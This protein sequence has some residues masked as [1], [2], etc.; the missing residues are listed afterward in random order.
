MN[1][2]LGKIYKAIQDVNSRL[3]ILETKQEQR[4][5]FNV[6]RMEKLDELPCKIHIER[7]NWFKKSLVSLYA[8]VCGIIT[9]LAKT[10]F[11][12]K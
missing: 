9:W 8:I 7:M 12:G 6:P 4:H 3:D 1:G 5:L 10:H 11:I 2:D